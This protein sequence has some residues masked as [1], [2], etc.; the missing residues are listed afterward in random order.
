MSPS[1][2]IPSRSLSARAYNGARRYKSA[3]AMI[4]FRSA[5]FLGSNHILLQGSMG[6]WK[7]RCLFNRFVLQRK[8]QI[9]GHIFIV[10]SGAHGALAPELP[11]GRHGAKGTKT[12]ITPFGW[13]GGGEVWHW[14]DELHGVFSFSTDARRVYTLKYYCIITSHVISSHTT[15]TL[16]LTCI[17]STHLDMVILICTCC[18]H[19]Q[20]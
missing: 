19:R 5:L 20:I 18:M 17:E 8:S 6:L 12:H 7:K 3:S 9:S 16:S 11:N 4:F 14:C 15:W 13:R 2:D 10:R 1:Q